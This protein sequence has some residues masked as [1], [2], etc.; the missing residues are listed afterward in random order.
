M[1][2]YKEL[3][4]NRAVHID[5]HQRNCIEETAFRATTT[6]VSVAVGTFCSCRT[7]GQVELREI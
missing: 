3:Y 7:Q 6:L 4:L 5:L 2:A 1:Y